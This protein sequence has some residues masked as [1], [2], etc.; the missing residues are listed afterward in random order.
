MIDWSYSTFIIHVKVL[1]PLIW[2]AFLLLCN[3]KITSTH[4]SASMS[5]TSTDIFCSFR[6]CSNLHCISC[7]FAVYMFDNFKW[8][9]NT[10]Y[11]FLRTNMPEFERVKDH[12]LLSEGCRAYACQCSHYSTS[13]MKEVKCVPV[14]SWVCRSHSRQSLGSQ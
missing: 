7:D 4:C 6:T 5:Y 12:L 2:A 1:R 8:L 3:S 14:L 10:D 13:I 11:L 9:P